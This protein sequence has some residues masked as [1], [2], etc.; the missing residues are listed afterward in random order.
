MLQLIK[1]WIRTKKEEYR[2]EQFAE[3]FAWVM[4]HY[5]LGKLDVKDITAM[6]DDADNAFNDGVIEAIRT[7]KED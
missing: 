3:G 1:H 7:I 2:E 5:H 6:L 4:V